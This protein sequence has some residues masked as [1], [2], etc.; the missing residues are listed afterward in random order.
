LNHLTHLFLKLN[1]LLFNEF[2]LLINNF[3]RTIQ[4]LHLSV[5]GAI[6]DDGYVNANRWEDLILSS[7]PFLRVFDIHAKAIR[8]PSILQF[9]QF[10]SPFWLDRQWFFVEEGCFSGNRDYCI[11]TMYSINP[12][13]YG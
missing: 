13:R 8:L 11:I 4:V 2:G 12:Y 1:S 10:S 7:M 5:I 3:F 9:D 6:G